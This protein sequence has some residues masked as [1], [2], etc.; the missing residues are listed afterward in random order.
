MRSLAA[1]ILGGLISAAVAQATTWHILPDGTGDAPTIAAGLDSASAGDTVEV[2]CGTCFENELGLKSGV[3]LRSATGQ[4][5]CA[6]IDGGASGS[7]LLA[8]SDRPCCVL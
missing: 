5:D 8:F 3:T 2:A 7:V 6:T 4:P 1:G